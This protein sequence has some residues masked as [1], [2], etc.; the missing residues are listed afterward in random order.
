MS[1]ERTFEEIKKNLKELKTCLEECKSDNERI[2]LFIA[3]GNSYLLIS[4]AEESRNN[5]INALLS[6]DEAEK[7]S[8]KLNNNEA[9]IN[10]KKLKGFLFYKLAFLEDRNSN[11]KLSIQHYKNA[12]DLI[13]DSDREKLISVNYNLAN[14]YL[15]LRDG[16]EQNNILEAIFIFNNALEIANISGR[17]DNLSL[18]YN[19]IARSYLILSQFYSGNDLHDI[20]EKAILYFEESLKFS[21]L[22]EDPFDFASSHNGLGIAHMR[23]GDIGLDPQKN[24]MDAV[25]HFNLALKLYDVESTPVDFASVN[26]SIGLCYFKLSQISSEEKK[27]FLLKA[28]DYLE[29]S[30]EYFVEETNPLELSNA[31]YNLSIVYKDLFVLSNNSSFLDKEIQN[32][33]E[34]LKFF[35]EVDNPVNYATIQFL[36]GEAFYR[37]GN[38]KGSLGYYSEA[39]RVAEK[40]N[41]DLARQITS[42]KK[43]IQSLQ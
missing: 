29:T 7:I 31:E 33:N 13:G 35:K 19:A 40:F 3:I 21:S 11:L 10:V 5:I 2:Q 30:T 6:F 34:A 15:A 28:K 42:V 16:N 24:Y 12:I 9:Q 22:D 43:V 4:E 26:Y 37:Q 1:L 8:S 41:P 36:I 14:S 18:I 20:F 27:E 17:S 32:L 39:E 38:I 25:T 23:I